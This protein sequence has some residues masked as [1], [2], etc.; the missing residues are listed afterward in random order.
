M[1]QIMKKAILTLGIFSMMLVLTSFTS[2]QEIGGNQT[3]PAP[4]GKQ[5]GGIYEIG[6]NQTTPAPPAKDLTADI[7]G[8]QT[9]PKPP[10][11]NTNIYEIGGT[12][13]TPAPPNRSVNV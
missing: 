7:G 1:S 13:T 6:G 12:Q 8:N 5:V 3:T 9:T 11:K 4:P 2:P 10:V